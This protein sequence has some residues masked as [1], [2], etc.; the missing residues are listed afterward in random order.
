VEKNNVNILTLFPEYFYGLKKTSIIKRAIE[1]DVVDINI[2][3]IRDYSTDKHGSVDDTPYG[4]GPGMV[5]KCQ[6][7]V[8]AMKDV[9]G[10]IIM[11]SPQGKKFD[12]NKAIELSKKSNITL[13]CGHYEGFDERI[14]NYVDEEISIGDFVLTGG[15]SAAAV[16]ADAT[17]RLMDGVIKQES[18]AEDSFAN[19]LIEA[20]QYT[21]P[22]SYDGMD[23][24]EV[25]MSGDHKKIE[26]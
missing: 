15:E 13:V 3:N 25:L 22:A 19:G 8:D 20:P 12:H 18:V 11:L 21:R 6:P 1:K 24:P 4:G 10:H 17:I 14:R 26:E 9:E 16:I 23:V 5:L 2:I 7:V